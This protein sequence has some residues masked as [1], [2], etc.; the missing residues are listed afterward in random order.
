MAIEK[1]IKVGIPEYQYLFDHLGRHQE[2]GVCIIILKYGKLY[3]F[4]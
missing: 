3:R 2:A 4:P 1:A